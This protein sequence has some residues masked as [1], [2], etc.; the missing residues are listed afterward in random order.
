MSGFL[1]LMRGSRAA[2]AMRW[3]GWSRAMPVM[4]GVL[5]ALVVAILQAPAPAMAM[6]NGSGVMV[7]KGFDTCQD[8]T[9]SHMQAFWNG[10][11]YGWVGT[12]IG[13]SNMACSQPNLSATWLNQV[14]SQGWNFEF[15]WVGP[16]SPCTT[17]R[18]RFSTNSSTAFSQGES[19][20]S[21]AWLKLT[22]LGITNNAVNTALVYDLEASPSACQSETNAFIRGWVTQLHI[23][24]AQKA[25]VYGSVCGS[26]LSSY[27]NIS[28][29]PDFIWGADY[30]GNPS[31]GDL[32]AGGCGVPS[33]EWTNHQRLK[34]YKGGHNETWNGVTLYVDDDC[35]NG[36]VD[37][38]GG[39]PINSACY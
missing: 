35:A 5:A 38:T 12:Y 8:P 3:T 33:T 1:G 39:G 21:S 36:P 6:S 7:E 16:Q 13:G 32:N 18:Y 24:P 31:T 30:N 11:P 4:V 27:W 37:P 10:T 23:S 2:R 14:R 20:A 26:S 29:R 17:Y 34:Q 28:P 15:I 19:E 25:G 9:V 22:N